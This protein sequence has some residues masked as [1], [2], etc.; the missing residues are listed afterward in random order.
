MKIL[1]NK[2]KHAAIAVACSLT[3]VSCSDFLEV[4]PM[5]FVSEDNFWNEKT[6]IDQMVAGC[7]TK[8]QADAFIQRCIMWG[9]TRCDNIVEGLD[10]SNQTSIYRTLKEN[11][12]STNS[13]TDW[14]SFY[15]VINQCNTIIERAPEV[16]EQ[17]PTYTESDVNATI[18][19]MKGM[20]ALCYFYLVRAFKDVPYYTYAI[21][22]EDDVQ[23]IAATS[24]DSIVGALIVDLEDCVSDAL[25]AFPTGDDAS[26]YN[27][28]RNRITQNTIYSLLADLCLWNG[29]YQK[30][31][32]Y[33]QRVIDAKYEEYEEEYSQSTGM[34]NGDI[35]LFKHTNDTYDTNGF[36]LYPCFSGNTYGNNFNE[37]FGGDQCSFESIFE[38]AFTNTSSSTNYIANTAFATLYG[39]HY[40]SSGNDGK[41]YLAVTEDLV[42]D[43]S[44]SI[45]GNYY[46]RYDVRYYTD[47]NNESFSSGEF[48]E[49]YVNKGVASEVNVSVASGATLPFSPTSMNLTYA[50]R[51]FI[52]YRLT[53]VMLMQAEALA[54]LGSAT[55]E[56]ELD[57]N[58]KHAFYIV[59]A[60]NRRSIMTN[61]STATSSYEL[62]LNNYSSQDMIRE[63]VLK[64]R[65][66]ELMFEGKR[67]FDLLRQCHRA[68]TTDYIKSR[69]SAKGSSSSTTLF[70][71]Y[72]A[73]FWPY[74]KT[75]VKNNSLLD[76]KSYYGE[77]DE[78]SYQSTK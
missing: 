51:N 66:I 16:S 33:A 67:W 41:G 24:G 43:V 65:R 25:K 42:G 18:A 76:Q 72:E 37:I 11:L 48:T 71:N 14:T 23:D 64:E 61:S 36:P 32:D 29:D 75:E 60:V 8:M 20:R 12:L 39:N 38:L 40:T 50:N 10:C 13:Y 45:T 9:E 47:L 3:M 59:W 35:A 7:Y 46:T 52:F 17:D 58:L 57:D 27:T 5:T 2:F 22:S 77:D 73:L 68:G 70:S 69:V 62:S 34:S 53:D 4:E 6:D 55:A 15:A 63:L 19:E 31:V 21:Q 26:N 28:T 56:G 30:T 49:A 74:N 1:S 78:D 54:E 44:S